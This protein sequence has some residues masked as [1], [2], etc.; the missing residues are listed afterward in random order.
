MTTPQTF[1][2]LKDYTNFKSIEE[3]DNHVKMHVQTFY[4]DLKQSAREVLHAIAGHALAFVG[5]AH[6]KA[7]TIAE[8]IGMSVKSVYRATKELAEFGIIAKENKPK[9]NGIKG[10]NIYS[11]L[12]CVQSNV[13]SGMSHR[14]NEEKPCERKPEHVNSDDQSLI[15]LSTNKS[16]KDTNITKTYADNLLVDKEAVKKQALLA[17]IPEALHGLKMYFDN[18]QEI[19]DMVGVIYSAKNS[20][21]KAVRVE[22]HANLFNKTINSVYEYWQRQIKKGNVDY[23][24]FGLM[25]K[26]IR[27]LVAKIVD[28]SAYDVPTKKAKQAV[29]PARKFEKAPD[30]MP[31][32]KALFNSRELVPDWMENRNEAV[33]P[34]QTSDQ[35]IDFE[36]E[37]R[38]VLQKLEAIHS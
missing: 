24:A 2:Y 14:E 25:T 7:E 17:K 30:W 12:P 19:H 36:E 34:V 28:G 20:V 8:E 18:A 32:D 1:N 27:E 21:D 3:M 22:D 5:A 16:F 26:A 10:A 31:V 33:A 11:I 37:R 9:K 38:K 13:P 29:V 6:L 15:L 4:N 35:T 23:N